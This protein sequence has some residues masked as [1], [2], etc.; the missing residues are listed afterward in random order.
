M[1]DTNQISI[2]AAFIDAAMCAVSKEETRY[3]LKGVFLDARG[4]I[5]A[6]NGHMAFAARC[7]DAYKLAGVMPTYP[8]DALPGVIVPSDAIR[9][10]GKAAGRSKGLCYVVE[11]DAQGLWW[12]LYGNARIHFAP[13]DGSF[14]DWARIIPIAPVDL[15][16]AHF[17]PL[18]IGKLGDMAKALRDGKKD[19]ASLFK[20][21]Q[22]GENPALVTFASEDGLGQRTDCCG[23]LM[24][25]REKGESAFDRDAF[26]AA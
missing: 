19:A 26:I 8:S 11:R 3:Y 24:P 2:P 4:F 17:N 22:N 25:M 6:T 9:Q 13:V 12:I 16:A 21:H 20:L 10:A 23:V 15:V 7:N 14:P 5:A 18:Y 1:T